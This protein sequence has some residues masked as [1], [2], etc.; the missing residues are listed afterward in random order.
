[1]DAAQRLFDRD[2]V[3]AG[4]N[5]NEV[6]TEA[7]VNR[8]QIYQ[9][10]GSRRELLRATLVRSLD[11]FRQVLPAHFAGSF[12]ERRKAL[13][14]FVLAER[15]MVRALA[16]LVLD[17]DEEFRVMPEFARTLEALERDQREGALAAGADGPALHVLT[18]SACYGYVML[19]EAIARDTDI[20]LD[21]LDE[22]VRAAYDRMVE[23]LVED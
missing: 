1:M 18:A 6:A 16:L 9:M 20:P 3:L 7:G 12:A 14:R 15:P 21:E 4:L 2:G 5:L 10:Y 22:R 17:G 23:R 19:R 13:L 8:G 11:R